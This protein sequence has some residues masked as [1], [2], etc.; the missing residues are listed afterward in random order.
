MKAGL[1]TYPYLQW[2]Y[3]CFV[4]GLTSALSLPCALSCGG[5]VGVYSSLNLPCGLLS[6]TSSVELLYYVGT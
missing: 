1:I 4:F 6:Y 5:A 2:A 3:E